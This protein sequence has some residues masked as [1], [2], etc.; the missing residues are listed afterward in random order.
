MMHDRDT[1]SQPSDCQPLGMLHRELKIHKTTLSSYF[2]GDRPYKCEQC[3]KSFRS[4]FDLRRHLLVHD[5][6]RNRIEGLKFKPKEKKV[7]SEKDEKIEI[8]A[9]QKSKKVTLSP[10]ILKK[11]PKKKSP[12]S[13]KG[14][15]NVTVQNRDGQF[16]PNDYPDSEEFERPQFTKFKVVYSESEFKDNIVYKTQP[17]KDS[18]R[19]G[20]AVHRPMAREDR[21][22]RE[23]T[24]GKLQIFTH[25]EKGKDYSGNIVT[26]SH[27]LGDIRHLEREVA[28]DVR[29]DGN[30]NGEVMESAFFEQF[31]ELYSVQ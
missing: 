12:A 8:S 13:R 25:V 30:M 22:Y 11:S 10:T 23:N 7:K 24:D 4:S 20:F 16:K 14:A 18:D 15:P 17:Y 19:A 27:V 31:S 28:R 6:I 21:Q 2:S 9:E 1:S 5:K 3:E 26:N 29:S